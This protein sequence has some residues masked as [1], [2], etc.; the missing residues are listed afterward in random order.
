MSKREILSQTRFGHRVAEE[1][2]DQLSSYFVE[3]DQWARVFNGEIDVVFGPKGSGKSAIYALLL[4]RANDL[5]DSQVLLASAENPQ[6][7][8]AFQGIIEDPPTSEAEFRGL[9][10]LYFLS[11]ISRV[12]DEYGIK[13]ENSR[14]LK[15]VLEDEG[16]LPPAKG[17]Q[18]VLSA[19]RFYVSR[20]FR[21]QAV[22][23][24]VELDP[25]TGVARAIKGKIIFADPTP[26]DRERGFSSVDELLSLANE[27]FNQAG[28]ELW[29]LLD[30]LDV[31]FAEH[32]ELERNALRALFRVY[33]DLAG[34]Q[35][36]H[37][38]IFLR[39]DIWDKLA[40]QGFR[41]ASHIT[42]QVTITWDESSLLN[43]IVRRALRNEAIQQHLAVDPVAIIA[44]LDAQAQF[45]Y[46]L[47]P[48]QVD[49][50]EKKPSTLDWIISRTRDGL[51]RTAPREVIHLLNS[52]R[53]VQI[54]RIEKGQ[55]E[56]EGE[57]LFERI[58]FKEALREV[59]SSKVN[60]TLLAENPSLSEY[61]L[62]L[63]GQKATQYPQSIASIWG[64]SEEDARGVS[65]Q[66]AKAGFFEVRE[67]N[68]QPEYWVPFLFRD[69]L[70]LVQGAAE[71]E[72]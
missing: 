58:T 43:L 62:R 51:K 21:A 17:L 64:L 12:L 32:E 34:H 33:L 36:I 40:A 47:F 56:P 60:Q 38:K 63:R 69:A 53:E 68:G 13:D 30:R 52:L 70:E 9:W 41:E 27:S 48:N 3:T 61:V 24:G 46:R 67:L 10:K 4:S 2:Q 26:P 71:L 16:L 6:G 55:P 65:D 5:F 57:L 28:Y 45:F 66:L 18:G 29:L 15:R 23:G 35:R 59:S 31:A 49:V 14:A 25:L 19:A 22:E 11:L 20:A 1:E 54:A 42:K 72:E 8:P 39:S 50:G 7:T 37:L 44:S